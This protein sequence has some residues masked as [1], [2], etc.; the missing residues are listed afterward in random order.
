MLKKGQ[1]GE[2]FRSLC[3]LRD[4]SLQAARELYY[5]NAQIQAEVSLLPARS[6]D[7]IE[8]NA[9]VS[10]AKST[11]AKRPLQIESASNMRD[12]GLRR[13]AVTH[14]HKASRHVDDSQL[15]EFQRRVKQTNY[16]TRL[17]Q[18]F[19]NKRTRRAT[20]AT[21]VVMLGKLDNQYVTD[22]LLMVIKVNNFAASISLRSTAPTSLKTSTAARK[23]T[24][25]LPKVSGSAGA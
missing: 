25:A 6:K 5:A 1:L 3:A 8:L 22:Y 11:G 24:Q 15:D 7:D 16:F 23:V 21:F 9:H 18:L 12:G 20:L 10:E 19:R 13:R 17:W 2:A 4:T 14:W